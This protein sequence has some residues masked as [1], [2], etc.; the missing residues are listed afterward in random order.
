[1]SRKTGWERKN[2]QIS[3]WSKSERTKIKG[4]KKRNGPKVWLRWW[5]GGRG[6]GGW[7]IKQ[8]WGG[9][10]GIL[11]L[12]QMVHCLP[13]HWR[14]V[15]T[16]VSMFVCA[17]SNNGFFYDDDNDEDEGASSYMNCQQLPSYSL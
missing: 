15:Q 4:R 2:K 3:T 13:W 14:Q 12:V 17:C 8:Q 7:G 11:Q 1:M 10:G 5:K 16:C 9:G 6:G